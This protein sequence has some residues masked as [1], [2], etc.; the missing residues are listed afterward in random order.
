MYCQPKYDLKQKKVIM[1]V[2]VRQEYK[3]KYLGFAT[4]KELT[5]KRKKAKA[6]DVTDIIIN[7]FK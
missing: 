5:A 6:R 1:T 7:D 2:P 3:S 4:E